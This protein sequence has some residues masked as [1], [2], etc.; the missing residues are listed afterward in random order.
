MKRQAFRLH[1]I[2]SVS[3]SVPENMSPDAQTLCAFSPATAP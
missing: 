2:T 3:L 1:V